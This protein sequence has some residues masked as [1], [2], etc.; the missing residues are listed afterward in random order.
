MILMESDA[1]KGNNFYVLMKM[2]KKKTCV[3]V[4]FGSLGAGSWF[5][6]VKKHEDFECI[7]VVDTNTEL[8]ENLGN[9][10]IDED[11]RRAI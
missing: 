4:G 11:H 2:G 10:G 7:G 1:C 8:L 9:F 3:V 5:K 6:Q